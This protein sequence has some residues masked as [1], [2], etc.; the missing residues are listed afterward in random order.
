MKEEVLRESIRNEIK[1]NLARRAFAEEFDYMLME[2]EVNEDVGGFL[3][4]LTG[5]IG[6]AFSFV[7][8]NFGEA[9]TDSFKQFLF[10]KTFEY[11]EEVGLPISPDSVF[12]KAIINVLESLQWSKL[13]TY[14]DDDG[15]IDLTNDIIKGLQEGLIQ[16]TVMDEIAELFFG[17]GARVE[18]FVG[19]PMRELIN[20]KLQEMTE[21]LRK[22]FLDFICKNRDL[23][24]LA[25]DLKTAAFSKGFEG[26][27]PSAID[28]LNLPKLS[29]RE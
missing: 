6:D 1:K 8:D 26:S 27:L 13:G 29:L 9:I 10:T 28:D 24:Q 22:P 19:G 5:G 2:A 25:S 3:D 15:C 20:I 14:L 12:G 7:E 17:Q 4:T 16:E 11:L 23:G 18:G 21:S